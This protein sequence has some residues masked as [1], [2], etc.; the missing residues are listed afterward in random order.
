MVLDVA[1]FWV[2][3]SVSFCLIGFLF[4]CYNFIVFVWR[5]E[6][7]CVCLCVCV[8]EKERERERACA[9]FSKIIERRRRESGNCWRRGK[10]DQNI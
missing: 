10:Y 3:V 8:C 7:E 2:F 5:G 6:R 1:A 4:I 9:W